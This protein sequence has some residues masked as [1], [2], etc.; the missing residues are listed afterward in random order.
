MAD[1]HLAYLIVFFGDSE[2]EPEGC[3]DGN[4]SRERRE[5]VV[6]R[7]SELPGLLVVVRDGLRI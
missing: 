5:T 1:W 2:A 7:V 4:W 3:G 6:G